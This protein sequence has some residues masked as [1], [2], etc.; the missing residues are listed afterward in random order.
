MARE[1]RFFEDSS[2]G[3]SSAGGRLSLLGESFRLVDR[4]VTEV[5]SE[6]TEADLFR[7]ARRI[8]GFCF[9]YGRVE[10]GLEVLRPTS[11]ALV[12]ANTLIGAGFEGAYL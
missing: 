6:S 8:V 7:W 1:D 2:A 9:G 12:S 4:L 11:A 10:T 5:I 3:Y